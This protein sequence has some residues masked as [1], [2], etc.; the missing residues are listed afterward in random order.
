MSL[1]LKQTLNFRGKKLLLVLVAL[2]LAVPGVGV[3]ALTRGLDLNALDQDK[4]APAQSK[5]YQAGKEAGAAEARRREERER[6]IARS[7]EQDSGYK[8]E[9][10]ERQRLEEAEVTAKQTMQATLVNLAKIPMDQAIQIALTQQPGKVLA[11][12]IV[13]EHWESVGKLTKDSKVLYHVVIISGDDATPITTHVLVN[14]IDGA[15]VKAEK[16]ERGRE[17]SR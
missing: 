10:A 8:A 7:G 16:E 17:R 13:A 14:A 4:T 15:V 12:S 3:L 5:E 1:T 9:I 11:A 6:E 2:F